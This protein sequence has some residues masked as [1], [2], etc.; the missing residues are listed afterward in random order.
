MVG[1]CYVVTTFRNPEEYIMWVISQ[2]LLFTF[3]EWP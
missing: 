3:V 2:H 1:I